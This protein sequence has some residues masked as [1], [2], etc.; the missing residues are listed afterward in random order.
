MS[1]KEEIEKIFNRI[2]NKIKAIEEVSEIFGL[3]KTSANIYY[4]EWMCRKRDNG[5]LKEKAFKYLNTEW[6]EG[7]KKLIFYNYMQQIGIKKSTA[8]QYFY[9][10]ETKRE[11]EKL[12]SEEPKYIPKLVRVSQKFYIDDSKLWR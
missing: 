7:D 12:M 11:A 2:K 5:T 10:W 8:Y 1:R 4:S 9:E 3:K 6:K